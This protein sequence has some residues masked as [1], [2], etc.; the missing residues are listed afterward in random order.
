METNSSPR[1]SILSSHYLSSHT[2]PSP[3]FS[4]CI[5]SSSSQHHSF[6]FY[7]ACFISWTTFA[8]SQRPTVAHLPLAFVSAPHPRILTLSSFIPTL[9]LLDHLGR[10]P[11]P[12]SS[13]F[14]PLAGSCASP[15][16]RA[17]HPEASRCQSGVLAAGCVFGALPAALNSLRPLCSS[18]CGLI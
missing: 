9:H 15:H 13:P 14:S 6:T 18:L 1:L 4:L 5:C 10:L 3:L 16:R 17:R 7:P 2:P 12:Y 8:A 11:A